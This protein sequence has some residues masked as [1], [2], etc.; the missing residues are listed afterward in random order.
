MLCGPIHMFCSVDPM[1]SACT[2]V[3]RIFYC[4]WAHRSRR[5]VPSPNMLWFIT[6]FFLLLKTAS[7]HNNFLLAFYV[8]LNENTSVCLEATLCSLVEGYHY[9]RVGFCIRLHVWRLSL[10]F[11]CEN[12]LFLTTRYRGVNTLYGC[13]ERGIRPEPWANQ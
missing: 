5:V 11:G 4:S 7:L 12:L 2:A 3:Q 13:R 8:D 6:Q 9:F 10:H 1:A